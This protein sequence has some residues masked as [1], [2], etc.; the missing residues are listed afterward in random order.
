MDGSLVG[1][2][3]VAGPNRASLC[4]YYRQPHVATVQQFAVD[5]LIQ[6]TGIG[7]ILLERCELW[8]LEKGFREIALDTADLATHLISFYSAKGY[9]VSGTVFWPGK[10][11]RS[12]VMTKTIA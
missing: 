6:K 4:E 12:L 5:P 10:S 1:T 3:V 7:S 9:V 2:I 8:A 11:Y